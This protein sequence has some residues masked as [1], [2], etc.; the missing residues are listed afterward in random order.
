MGHIISK[1][2]NVVDP[3]KIKDIVKLT[4]PRNVIEVRSIM[5]LAGYYQ[6]Y[7]KGFSK[8]A[9]PIIFLQ[10]KSAKFLWTKN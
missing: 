3:D 5:G 2:G 4:M 7:I 10:R 1:Q 8:I 6:W 9:H